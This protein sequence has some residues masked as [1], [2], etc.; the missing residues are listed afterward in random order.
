MHQKTSAAK[1][2][3]CQNHKDRHEEENVPTD[4][5]AEKYHHQDHDAKR[6]EHFE[7]VH[8]NFYKQQNEFGEVDLG[9]NGLV[10]LDGGHAGLQR[11][12]EKGPHGQTDKNVCRKILLPG[13][14][15]IAK[16]ERIDQHEA[17]WL[18]DPPNPV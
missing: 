17:K 15:H 9:N 12:V 7:S 13:V 3:Q 8:P 1:G 16:D 10:F 14:I 4:G 6:N 11:F 18:Q 2:Q 5:D